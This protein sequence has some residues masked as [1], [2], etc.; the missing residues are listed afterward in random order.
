MER[1]PF[2]CDANQ[3][4][5]EVV[6]R[7]TDLERVRLS[8]CV[9]VCRRYESLSVKCP[10]DCESECQL[11][12]QPN[13]E[14]ENGEACL[15]HVCVRLQSVLDVCVRPQSGLDVCATH[16]WYQC[17][18]PSVLNDFGACV[19]GL[20]VQNVGA[21]TLHD[22]SVFEGQPDLSG[23]ALSSMGRHACEANLN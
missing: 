22:L 10:G 11:C 23:D 9:V 6:C 15:L 2:A 13:E 12:E 19:L 5:C 1:R 17:V 3:Y 16:Q 18:C 21:K 4:D 8:D 7:P 20:N 14:S